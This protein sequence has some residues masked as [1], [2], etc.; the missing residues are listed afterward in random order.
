MNQADLVDRAVNHTTIAMTTLYEDEYALRFPFALQTILTATN[1]GYHVVVV[2]ASL[3]DMVKSLME[4]AGAIVHDQLGEGMG[5][6]KRQAVRKA[7]ENPKSNMPIVLTCEPEKFGLV[8]HIPG[9]VAPILHG[10]AGYVVAGRT[11]RSKSTYPDSQ[12]QSVFLESTGLDFD[13]AFAPLAFPAHN[14]HHFTGYDGAKFGLSDKWDSTHL[15][16]VFAHAAGVNVVRVDVDFRYPSAQKALEEIDEAMAE[17]RAKQREELC[18]AYEVIG[19]HLG[20][21]R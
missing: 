20:L 8:Q 2:D 9:I 12:I 11:A 18:R 16:A 21:P 15:P 6:Q 1:K 19:K 3:N 7:L 17:K 4:E 14:A 10:M 5:N 13:V